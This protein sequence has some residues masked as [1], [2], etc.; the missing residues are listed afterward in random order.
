MR[1]AIVADREV[2]P[3][4]CALQGRRREL[5][6][7]IVTA[8][9]TLYGNRLGEHTERLAHH[10]VRGD[11]RDKAVGYLRRA[12]GKA[13]ARAALEDARGL[14][15]QA[16]GV[17][18]ALPESQ[19]TLE[20]GFETRLELRS[21]LNKLGQARQVLERVRARRLGDH[22][23]ECTPRHPGYAAY[24]Q[25]LLGDVA[26]HPH[27]FDAERGEAHY[28][29]ALV[30]AEP[31][32]MR[33]LVA[34]CHLGLGTLY[35]RTGD[36]AKAKEHLATAATMYREMGMSFWREKADAELRGVAR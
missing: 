17:L 26:A 34:H 25:Q 27:R 29:Q 19:F 2:L 13:A 10:A 30:L 8:V 6:A 22:A 31:R 18:D 23:I 9:E 21:V 7:R 15:E 33:P 36:T 14:F 28:R 3:R 1:S 12:G 11:L 16:L 35:R 5:H 32:G 20:Q 24:A 4:V